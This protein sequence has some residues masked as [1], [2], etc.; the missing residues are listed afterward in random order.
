MAAVFELSIDM[1]CIS[2]FD[3]HF[4]EVNPAFEAALGFTA[5]ELCTSSY[6]DFIHP[7]DIEKT[8]Q[9]VENS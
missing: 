3:G 2:S 1:L 9:E 6:L 5:E 7:D 8:A 4:K